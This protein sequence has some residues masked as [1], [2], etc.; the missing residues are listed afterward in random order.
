M[1]TSPATAIALI[2]LIAPAGVLPASAQTPAAPLKLVEIDGRT[3]PFALPQY[4]VWA[5]NFRTFHRRLVIKG[6]EDDLRGAINLGPA[7]MKLVFAA[8]DA[9]VSSQAV[10]DRDLQLGMSELRAAT[11]PA[12]N[13][14]AFYQ[15]KT[16]ACR[17]QL[18][19]SVDDLLLR[20]TP[21]GQKALLAYVDQSRR[22]LGATMQEAEVAFFRLPR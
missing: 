13:Q 21:R 20:L 8:A 19:K 2:F 11:A 12:E 15:A 4:F 1:K 16:L 5:S 18:L 17:E 14:T 10:C 9:H 22:S 6:F 3:T 7:D